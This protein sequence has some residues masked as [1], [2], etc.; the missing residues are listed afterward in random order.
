[1]AGDALPPPHL[2]LAASVVPTDDSRR[3]NRCR[4]LRARPAVAELGTDRDFAESVQRVLRCYGHRERVGHPHHASTGPWRLEIAGSRASCDCR[5]AGDRDLMVRGVPRREVRSHQPRRQLGSPVGPQARSDPRSIR[6][7]NSSAWSP[8]GADSARRRLC[9]GEAA[10]GGAAELVPG[11]DVQLQEDFVQVV[12]D[13]SGADEQPRADIGVGEAVP[14]EPGD[15]CLLRCEDV[16]GLV[17][18]P[19][20]GPPG[21]PAARGGRARRTPRPPCD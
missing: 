12:L 17:D 4:G 19:A 7:A 14:C 2:H 13:G 3:S 21:G 10:G 9:H 11:A 8:P 20:D 1:M 5:N 15:L 6:R 18:A 16:A